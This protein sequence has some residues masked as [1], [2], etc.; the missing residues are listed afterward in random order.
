MVLR[1]RS[2]RRATPGSRIARLELG[3]RRFG[4]RAGQAV[5]LGLPGQ[6]SR[7]PYSIAGAPADARADR[8]LEFLIKT[9]ERGGF[10][11]HLTGLRRGAQVEVD[12]PFGSFVFPLATRARQLLF[13]AGGAG[14]APLRSMLRQALSERYPGRL[15]VLYSARSPRDFAYGRELRQ[16][17]RQG[18]IDLVQ[19]VTRNAPAGWRGHRGRID[20]AMLA[21]AVRAQSTLCFVCGPPGLVAAVLRI[22]ADLG[23]SPGRIRTEAWKA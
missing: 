9:D 10:G 4:Y 21:S 15:T 16:L 18:R 13:V 5:R 23:V 11:P 14:L 17:A 1:V 19:T 8:V 3:S 2:I 7:K 20:L 22:L 12:G 6:G